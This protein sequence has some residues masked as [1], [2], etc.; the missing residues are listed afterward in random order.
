MNLKQ[1]IEKQIVDTYL[2]SED[3]EDCRDNDDFQDILNWIKDL[4]KLLST[5]ILKAVEDNLPKKLSAPITD[6]KNDIFEEGYNQAIQEMKEKLRWR[7]K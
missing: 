2:K 7:K 4:A 6:K 1:Q 5:D 3:L